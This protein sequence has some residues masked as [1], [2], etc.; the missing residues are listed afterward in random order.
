[1]PRTVWLALI[2]LISLGALLTLRSNVGAPSARG[3]TTPLQTVSPDFPVDD[4]PPLAKSDRLSLPFVDKS[5]V[6]W[7]D[8]VQNLPAAPEAIPNTI[9]G[10][11]E[12]P[13]S[14]PDANEVKTWH[15]HAGSKVTKRT[16]VVQPKESRKAN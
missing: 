13:Q 5:A 3:E 7:R 4:K 9:Q 1:M 12:A 16:T 2:C 14:M 10:G 6:G 15:W 8:A 11:D